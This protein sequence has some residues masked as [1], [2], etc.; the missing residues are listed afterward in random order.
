[1]GTTS[2]PKPN[3]PTKNQG[4]AAGEAKTQATT[5]D[6]NDTWHAEHIGSAEPGYAQ[7]RA[8]GVEGRGGSKAP[9]TATET[10]DDVFTFFA[11]MLQP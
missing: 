6:N 9:R 10:V 5:P 11:V 3:L 2:P 8:G 7:R 1:M 4:A